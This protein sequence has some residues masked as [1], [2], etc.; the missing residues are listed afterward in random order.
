MVLMKTFAQTDRIFSVSQARSPGGQ[1]LHVLVPR[2]V[3]TSRWKTAEAVYHRLAPTH[4]PFDHR[5]P[6]MVNGRLVIPAGQ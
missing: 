6:G 1:S 3:W 5:A 2:I 4:A